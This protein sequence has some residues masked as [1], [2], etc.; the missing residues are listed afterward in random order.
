MQCLQEG[1]RRL[2]SIRERNLQFVQPIQRVH[3]WEHRAISYAV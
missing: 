3:S 1:F 2:G